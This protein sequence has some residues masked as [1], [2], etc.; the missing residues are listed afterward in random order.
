ML[1]CARQDDMADLARPMPIVSSVATLQRVLRRLG[2][3]AHAVPLRCE[4]CE[5][6]PKARASRPSQ[7]R[8]GLNIQP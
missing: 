5:L 3:R 8:E 1:K 2:V 6:E 4:R 7:A